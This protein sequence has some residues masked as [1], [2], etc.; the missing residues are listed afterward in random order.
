MKTHLYKD[1]KQ[2]V[3]NFSAYICEEIAQ[4]SIFH[5]ALSGGNTPK[6]LFDHLVQHYQEKIDWTKVHLYWGD[7]R[8]V[9]PQD[10]QSN[11]K[12]TMDR[13]ISHLSIPSKN[14]HRMLGEAPPALEANRYHDYL[15]T[16]LPLDRNQ[17]PVFD[18]MILGMGGDGH[19]ASIFPHQMELLKAASNCAV[20]THPESGQR[21]ISLTG[22]VIQA[23][24]RIHFLVIGGSKKE[25]AQQILQQQGNYLAYPAAHIQHAEWWLDEAAGGFL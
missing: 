5:I 21:R 11:Y 20:A 8:C 6:V 12:M 1:I 16:Q 14:I 3:A 4:A 24:K 7:E 18:L 9:P 19:T 22:E 10:E 15:N 2:V 23:A 17:R 25:V 13:L